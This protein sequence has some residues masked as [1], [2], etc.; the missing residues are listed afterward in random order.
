[1]EVLEYPDR[2]FHYQKHKF[3]REK[4]SEICDK[5]RDG[6]PMVSTEL[7]IFLK[8]WFL[9]HI[10]VDDVKYIKYIEGSELF[11]RPESEVLSASVKRQ[12]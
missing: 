4:M 5:I 12:A 8:D 2:Y 10:E 7:L 3:F 11:P 9:A 1:M 6:A